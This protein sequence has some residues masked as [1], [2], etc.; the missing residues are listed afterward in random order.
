MQGRDEADAHQVRAK[1]EVPPPG[2][3]GSLR[4]TSWDDD[5]MLSEFG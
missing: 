3:R 1:L 4:G 2:Y 5:A